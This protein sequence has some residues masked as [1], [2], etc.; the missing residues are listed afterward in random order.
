MKKR[1][2][3]RKRDENCEKCVSECDKREVYYILE[4]QTILFKSE[5][6]TEGKWWTRWNVFVHHTCASMYTH[7]VLLNS[8]SHSGKL[9]THFESPHSQTLMLSTG[10]TTHTI[11]YLMS[12]LNIIPCKMILESFEILSSQPQACPRVFVQKKNV[13][14]KK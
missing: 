13:P 14:A 5:T 3:L 7:T 11:I 12:L 6:Q 10:P 4:I 9:M 8:R 2:H 1:K